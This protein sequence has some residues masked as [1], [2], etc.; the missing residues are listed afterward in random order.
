MT[1]LSGI[2]LASEHCV[3]GTDYLPS[4]FSVLS[5]N[6][7]NKVNFLAVWVW[8]I[9]FVSSLLSLTRSPVHPTPGQ[10][11]GPVIKGWVI[12]CVRDS[13]EK[14]GAFVMKAE[15]VWKQE[16]VRIDQPLS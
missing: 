4:G 15:P 10:L 9:P 12:D 11:T 7:A 8:P 13:W 6:R 14:K 16:A 5:E 3:G 1:R 2:S